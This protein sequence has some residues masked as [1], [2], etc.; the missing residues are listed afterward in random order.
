MKLHTN[1]TSEE[2]AIKANGKASKCANKTK[3][4]HDSSKVSKSKGSSS[5]GPGTA[6]SSKNSQTPSQPK[7][8]RL[9]WNNVEAKVDS[10]KKKQQV[11]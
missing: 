11:Y 1:L 3:E 6:L 9:S 4:K 7:P 2:S 5:G 10:G 8:R